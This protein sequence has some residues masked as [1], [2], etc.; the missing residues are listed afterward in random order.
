MPRKIY[1]PRLL[2][3][4]IQATTE[5]TAVPSLEQAPDAVVP[6]LDPK[7]P[8]YPW[9]WCDVTV[10]ASYAGVTQEVTIKGV[11][12]NQTAFM[13]GAAYQAALVEVLTKMLHTLDRAA[14]A[15]RALGPKEGEKDP[16]A[17]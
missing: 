3:L 17:F 2:A 12:T 7:S 15:V 13:H 10:R 4:T 11:S 1:D 9:G 14:A 16:V 6:A 5:V 8:G